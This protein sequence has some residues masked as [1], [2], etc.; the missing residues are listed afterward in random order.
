MLILQKIMTTKQ[1]WYLNIILLSNIFTQLAWALYERYLSKS[2][3]I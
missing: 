1:D 3:S 2:W